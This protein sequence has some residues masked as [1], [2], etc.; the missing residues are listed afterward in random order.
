MLPEIFI[1]LFS[2]GLLAATAGSVV[3]YFLWKRSRVVKIDYEDIERL[4]QHRIGGEW[5]GIERRSGRERRSGN[6]RR[7]GLDRRKSM[8]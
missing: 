3:I 4:I 1:F 2:L 8:T 5:D 7:I 6:E